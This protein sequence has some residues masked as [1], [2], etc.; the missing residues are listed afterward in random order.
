[1]R[2]WNFRKWDWGMDWIELTQDRNSWQALENAV[3]NLWV[4]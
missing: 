1:M 3:M 4:P 2:G